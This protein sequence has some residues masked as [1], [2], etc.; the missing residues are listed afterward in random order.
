MSFDE[1]LELKNEGRGSKIEYIPGGSLYKSYNRNQE[2]WMNDE[3]YSCPS[4]SMVIK[5]LRENYD[6]HITIEVMKDEDG[7]TRWFFKIFSVQ[8]GNL[9]YVSGEN[10]GENG[11][12]DSYDDA[13][14][15]ALKY[16]LENLI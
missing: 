8:S 4:C 2:R 14:M 9:C 13:E 6:Y 7:I 15:S 1:E 12:Y 11:E 3:S 5:W 16:V 10:R